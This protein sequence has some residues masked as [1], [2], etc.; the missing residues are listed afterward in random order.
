[1]CIFPCSPELR[2]L[3]AHHQQIRQMRQSHIKVSDKYR[4][5]LFNFLFTFYCFVLSSLYSGSFYFLFFYQHLAGR[6]QTHGVPG[7][8]MGHTSNYVP[9]WNQSREPFL[10]GVPHRVL[11][12]PMARN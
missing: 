9:Y 8:A 5:N 1:M 3:I 11:H 10:Y 4:R 6:G 12:I 2:I 7:N